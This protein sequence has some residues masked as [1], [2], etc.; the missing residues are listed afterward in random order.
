EGGVHIEL[1]V[2]YLTDYM[3]RG[4][5]RSENLELTDPV[6]VIPPDFKP[7]GKEDAANL[8]I[9]SR[10]EWDLGR[11]PH[12]FLGVFVNVYDADPVSQ[13]QEIRPFF[14]AEWTVRP[15]ILAG[16]NNS[17]IFPDRDPFNTVEA[18]ASLTLDDS[19]F[20]KTDKPILSPYVFAA[21]DYDLY[22]G[23]YMEAGFNHEI[24]FEDLD[25]VL[26]GHAHVAYVN[27]NKQ[28]IYLDPSE[29][30]GWHHYQVGLTGQYMLNSALR[31]PPRYGDW[32]FEGYVYYT[33]GID[34]DLRS[35]TQMW[36]G[37]GIR[38][39]Y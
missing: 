26:I 20:F 14:G 30:S 19:Y 13:F 5:D 28:F 33:D 7:S 9:N 6:G 21:Y 25:I 31:I 16:G 29:D 23:L 38:F 35:N 12:P 11:L 1:A 37:G 36:G 17:Y 27:S 8:Q 15:F 4:I 24:E 32:S 34:N 3:F 18:F 39:R 22:D 10:L 2:S